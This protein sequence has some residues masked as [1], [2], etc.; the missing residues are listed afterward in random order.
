VQILL[1][2]G[3]AFPAAATAIM[4]YIRSESP[5]GH[6][7]IYSISQA[8]DDLFARAPERMLDL[9]S[10]VAG[11]APDRSLYGL[12]TALSKIEAIAP[13][14]AQTKQFQRMAAQASP[15]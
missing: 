7:S 11:D 2:T 1:A 5:R 12:T 9:L 15:Y 13:H 8:S 3:A 14:L 10:A 6:T 4:P